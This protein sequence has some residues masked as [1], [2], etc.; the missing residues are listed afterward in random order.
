MRQGGNHFGEHEPIRPGDPQ[1]TRGTHKFFQEE[2]DL[3][4][5]YI[6]QETLGEPGEPIHFFREPEDPIYFQG[7]RRSHVYFKELTGNL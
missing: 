4:N 1:G 6:S 2:P 5:S 7:T 3:E